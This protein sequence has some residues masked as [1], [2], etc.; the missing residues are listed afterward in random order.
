MPAQMTQASSLRTF[1][2]WP[3]LS[4]RLPPQLST[5]TTCMLKGLLH[6]HWQIFNLL[7]A[8]HE[9]YHCFHSEAERCSC[10]RNSAPINGS[11]PGAPERR[12]ENIP[13]L[14]VKTFCR[15]VSTPEGR[16]QNSPGLQAW[17]FVPKENRPERAAESELTTTHKH[18]VIFSHA[19]VPFASDRTRCLLNKGSPAVLTRH[20]T[21]FQG[22]FL[23]SCS[24][25]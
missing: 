17:E 3:P 15:P 2:T 11:S 4:L 5:E 24:Q 16:K 8:M 12:R 20:R 19:A 10:C 1:R 6:I 9:A 22:D 7:C 13:G 18:V 14:R 25:A 23:L 21:P